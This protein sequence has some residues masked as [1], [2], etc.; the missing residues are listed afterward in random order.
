MQGCSKLVHQ[1]LQVHEG[2]LIPRAKDW[3]SPFEFLWENAKDG[4]LKDASAKDM[5]VV[6]EGPGVEQEVARGQITSRGR[7]SGRSRDDY[8]K[9]HA[10]CMMPVDD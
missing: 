6:M 10:E 8:L 4:R 2:D 1:L 5:W 3:K 9:S 7:F